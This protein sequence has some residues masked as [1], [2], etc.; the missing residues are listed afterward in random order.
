[1]IALQTIIPRR[2]WRFTAAFLV[3]F[4]PVLEVAFDWRGLTLF[5]IFVVLPL[6]SRALGPD[7]GRNS[8]VIDATIVGKYDR[9]RIAVL[10][11]LPIAIIASGIMAAIVVCVDASQQWQWLTVIGWCVAAA[12]MTPALHELGHTRA[13]RAYRRIA[14]FFWFLAG[15]P[16]YWQEHVSIHHAGAARASAPTRGMSIYSFALQTIRVSPHNWIGIALYV[17]FLGGLIAGGFASA[18]MVCALQAL[19]T[20]IVVWAIAYIQHYGLPSERAWV[21]PCLIS[22]A[23]LFAITRH[24]AHH[25]RPAAP[26]WQLGLGRAPALLPATYTV[27]LFMAFIPSLW[28]RVM[29]K[30]VVRV[31]GWLD[32]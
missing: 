11:Q 29:D 30:R 3:P 31:T 9:L 16:S 1:M 7:F 8:E 22:N 26:F 12:M 2:F 19:V 15:L 28:R 32:R 21:D 14:K 27:L 20:W 4:L 5:V 25:Q 18:A 6:L 17:I 13:N 23:M 24:S 10:T